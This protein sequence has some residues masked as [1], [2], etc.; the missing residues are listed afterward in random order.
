MIYSEFQAGHG[1]TVI[2]WRAGEGGKER[3]REVP[4]A[5]TEHWLAF[6]TLQMQCAQLPHAPA[7]MPSLG[8]HSVSHSET[9]SPGILS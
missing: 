1:Y 3:E 7:T 4:R 9:F 6:T 5:Q 2:P 8:T